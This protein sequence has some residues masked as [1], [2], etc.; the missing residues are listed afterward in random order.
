MKKYLFH[1]I[2]LFASLFCSAMAFAQSTDAFSYVEKYN[3]KLDSIKNYQAVFTVTSSIPLLKI[4]VTKGKL[5]FKWPVHYSV[6]TYQFTVLPKQK[7]TPITRFLSRADF[8]AVDK[9][10]E[11]VNHYNCKVI[12]LVP[13]DTLSEVSQYTIWVDTVNYMVRRVFVSEKDGGEYVYHYRYK[14][15]SDLLPSRLLYTFN[16]TLP[17]VQNILLNPVALHSK[18]ESSKVYEGK[19]TIDFKYS[20]IRH[21]GD[22]N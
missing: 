8:K 9:G 5:F 19:I 13:Y 14:N 22:Q 15:S 3:Q 16:Y 21:L 20:G 12:E 10:L 18:V 7:L 1:T 6:S 11:L 4:P 2:L 17:H